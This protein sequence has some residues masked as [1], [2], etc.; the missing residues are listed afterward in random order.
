[1]F[2]AIY[3]IVNLNDGHATAYVGSTTNQRRRW[4][5]HRSELGRNVH[6]CDFLQRSWNRYGEDSFV[7]CVIEHAEN[8][9]LLDRE[10]FWLDR[11]RCSG[12][13]F[14]T[15]QDA[16]APML[17]RNHSEEA[18]AKISAA[19][20]G[21]KRSKETR[22]KMSMARSGQKIGPMAQDHKDKISVA[23]SGKAKT[24]EHKRKVGNANAK[25]YPSFV[26]KKSGEIISPGHNLTALCRE[27]DLDPRLMWPVVHGKRASHK[28][29][30]R[31]D[32]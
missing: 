4:N 13:I 8:N 24:E 12:R 21:T 20:I 26:H 27:R 28:G 1:M 5:R 17:G 18:C 22:R 6:H 3:S 16:I 19:H 31:R 14:N 29:W 15:A 25:P 9:N 7:F 30:Y 11:Y 2:G 23:L 32:S 10:Q